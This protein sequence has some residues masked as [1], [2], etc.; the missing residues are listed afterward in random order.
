MTKLL[1]LPIAIVSVLGLAA[2]GSEA[3]T[4][5]DADAATETTDQVSATAAGDGVTI[6]DSRYDPIEIGISVG[7]SVTWS[8]TDPFAH[9]IT[10]AAGSSVEY[11]SGELGQD[12]TF[13]QAFDEVGTYEYFCQIHPTMRASVVVS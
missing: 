2:C 6:K 5:S 3:D 9:T 7:E 10:S 12:A 4:S 1:F 8:N 13:E 11:D